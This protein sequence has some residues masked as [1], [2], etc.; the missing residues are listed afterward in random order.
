MQRWLAAT[1]RACQEDDGRRELLLRR[2]QCDTSCLVCARVCPANCGRANLL[3][4][5]SAA[6]VWPK[7]WRRTE[8][9]RLGKAGRANY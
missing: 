7:N 8:L 9:A 5:N 2:K 1:V 6:R 3:A 4:A